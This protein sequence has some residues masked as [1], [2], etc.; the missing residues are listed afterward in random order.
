MRI[1]SYI[2]SGDAFDND[3]FG[4]LIF[5]KQKGFIVYTWKYFWQVKLWC[6]LRKNKNLL[7]IFFLWTFFIDWIDSN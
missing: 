7:A 2:A 3:N 6:V 4:I 5:I 1:I